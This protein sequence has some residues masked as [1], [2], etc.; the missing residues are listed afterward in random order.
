MTT[1]PRVISDRN[2]LDR[3]YHRLATGDIIFGK[4]PMKAGEEHMLFDLASRGVRCIPSATAQLTSR[5][6][7][8]QA[9]TLSPWMLPETTVVYDIHQ[10]LSLCH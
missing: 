8:Y 4:I 1:A 9:L 10:L 6:K 2:S 3:H 7:C 5:S